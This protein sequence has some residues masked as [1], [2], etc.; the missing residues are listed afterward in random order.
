MY[1]VARER[2]QRDIV[3][4]PEQALDEEAVAELEHWFERRRALTPGSTAAG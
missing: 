1:A 2:I 3:A 4:D